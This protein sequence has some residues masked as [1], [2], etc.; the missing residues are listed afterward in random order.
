MKYNFYFYVEAALII[1]ILILLA[2]LTPIFLSSMAEAHGGV[3]SKS[4]AI[5]VLGH[6]NGLPDNR[7]Y[8]AGEI[9]TEP[10]SVFERP[11]P[12]V[13]WLFQWPWLPSVDEVRIKIAKEKMAEVYALEEALKPFEWPWNWEDFKKGLGL[14]LI[15]LGVIISITYGRTAVRMKNSI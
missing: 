2:I 10:R 14:A 1:A 13:K 8:I 15:S 12:E 9:W 6:V 5:P 11:Q 4:V 3:P 7:L